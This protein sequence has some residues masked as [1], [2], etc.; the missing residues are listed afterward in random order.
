MRKTQAKTQ[1][2]RVDNDNCMIVEVKKLCY[3]KWV[4]ECVRHSSIFRQNWAW[5]V[6][7]YS[8]SVYD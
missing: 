6:F 7:L 8:D 2:K 3:L 4:D 5:V 1:V